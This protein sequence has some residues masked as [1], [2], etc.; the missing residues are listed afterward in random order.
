MSSFL[1]IVVATTAVLTVF[2]IFEGRRQ[3]KKYGKA[4]GSASVVG[5]GMP[6]LQKHLQADRKVEVLLE[7]HEESRESTRTGDPKNPEGDA[8]A[9]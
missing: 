9:S 3:R 4:R 8:S 7:K 1:L 5:V 2:L 6:E